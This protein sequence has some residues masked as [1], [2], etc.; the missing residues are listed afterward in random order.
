MI[1]PLTRVLASLRFTLTATPIATELVFCASDTAAPVPSVRKLPS[2]L[3]ITCAPPAALIL[4]CTF[5]L[6]LCLLTV[7]PTAAATCT[8]WL[9]C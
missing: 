3:A 4:P 1:S 8:F 7:R 2:L 9:P 5:V 6:A